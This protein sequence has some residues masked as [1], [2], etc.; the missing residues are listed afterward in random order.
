MREGTGRAEGQEVV[1]A[2]ELGPPAAVTGTAHAGLA[3]R[4]ASQVAEALWLPGGIEAAEQAARVAAALAA[5]KG[6][7]PRDELEG[8]L[9]VQMVA[10]HGA[11]M[12]CLR[13]AAGGQADAAGRAAELRQAGRLIA[14]YAKQVEALN[15]HRGRGSQTVTVEHVQVRGG[16]TVMRQI[17]QERR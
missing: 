10:V 9:G 11:A 15:R 3:A 2:E 8:M 13:R 1:V 12:E 16:K 7:A 5:L 17:N 14:L 6:L 4:L